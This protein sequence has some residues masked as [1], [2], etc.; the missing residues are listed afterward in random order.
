MED[1]MRSTPGCDADSDNNTCGDALA[2][3]FFI[4]F[5]LLGN[6]LMLN[7]FT[8]IILLNFKDAAMDEGLAGEGFMSMAMFKMNQLDA[9]MSEFQRRYRVY[10]RRQEKPVWLYTTTDHS[11]NRQ[12]CPVCNSIP[13]LDQRYDDQLEA[14]VSPHYDGAR[15]GTAPMEQA[16]E[17]EEQG[18]SAV[19]NGFSESTLL[20]EANTAITEH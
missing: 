14:L 16:P 1:C 15:P 10:R 19:D 18:L 5:L 12:W 8:A 7:V 17:L 4:I 3:P 20:I 6:F 13:C 9:Y 2:A 11:F